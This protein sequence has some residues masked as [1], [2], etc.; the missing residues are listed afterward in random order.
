MDTGSEVSVIPPTPADR[1][2]QL[3]KFTLTAVNNTPICTYGKRFLNLN[4]GLRRPLSWT[5]VIAEVQKPIIGAD[6]LQHF[7]LLVDM[8][9]QLLTDGHTYIRPQEPRQSISHTIV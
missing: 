1:R 6:I 7:G 5:F 4:L 3:D 8:R 9:K 2:R